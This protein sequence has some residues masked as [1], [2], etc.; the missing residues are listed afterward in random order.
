MK[1]DSD[2][3]NPLPELLLA[4][5]SQFGSEPHLEDVSIRK[6]WS[7]ACVPGRREQPC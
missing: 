6:D 7:V 3:A 5:S 4:F 1:T 2:I